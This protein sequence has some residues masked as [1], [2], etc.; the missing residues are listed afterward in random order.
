MAFASLVATSPRRLHVA[1]LVN[2]PAGLKTVSKITT[3]Q[4]H[5]QTPAEQVFL[6][7]LADSINLHVDLS[8]FDASASRLPAGTP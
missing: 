7:K 8:L 4:G 1:I 6:R 2:G 3:E 5:V